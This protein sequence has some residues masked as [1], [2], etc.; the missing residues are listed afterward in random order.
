MKVTVLDDYQHAFQGLHAMERLHHKAEVQIFTEKFAS[1]AALIH[2]LKGSQAIIP[3]RERT[4]FPAH[5]LKALPDLEIIAQTRNHAYHIDIPAATEAGILVTQA[6]GGGGAPEIT[7]GLMLAVMRRLPQSDR[8]MR[9]GKWPLV[10]GRVLKGKTLGILGMGKVGSEVSRLAQ[11][12]GMKVIAWGPTLTKERAQKAGVTFMALEEVLKTADVVSVHLMLSEQSK[13]ILNEQR[14]RL[15]K[16]SAYLINTAR[17]AMI[18]ENA[19]VKVLREKAIA[20]AALDVFVEEPL[21][22]SSPLLEL[23]NVVLSPHLG[24]PT[25]AGF[26]GFAER[27]VENILNYME[28]KLT[29]ATNP[30]ALERRRRKSAI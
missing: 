18:D 19:L 30:E 7:L 10:L 15:M 25:D 14:L 13:G 16:K 27:A 2:A 8:E 5:L 3:I 11:A 4:H 12:F 23:D 22:P 9:Q 17:G 28:G 29:R 26:E 6:P 20:G 24:W 1:D 21:P